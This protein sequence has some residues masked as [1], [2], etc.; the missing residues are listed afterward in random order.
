MLTLDDYCSCWTQG[1]L[2]A[3]EYEWYITHQPIYGPISGF[4]LIHIPTI[5]LVVATATIYSM[6]TLHHM[7]RQSSRDSLS[8]ILTEAWEAF[9]L[10]CQQAFPINVLSCIKSMGKCFALLGGY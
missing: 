10:Q 4:S 6:Q 2:R 3:L 8:F 7:S 5:I 1:K 9:A